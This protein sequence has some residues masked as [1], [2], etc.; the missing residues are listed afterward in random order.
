MKNVM[1]LACASAL[2]IFAAQ[3]ANAQSLRNASGPAERPPLSYTAS[4]FVDSKGCVYIRAG[5][6]GSVTWVPRV[7][8]S[9]KLM[10]GAKPSLVAGSE[11]VD[12]RGESAIKETTVAAASVRAPVRT[13]APVPAM[14][15]SMG[16]TPKPVA[17][18]AAPVVIKK[19]AS[20]API[21]TATAKRPSNG[22]FFGLLFGNN[23]RTTGAKT[24]KAPAPKIVVAA[25]PAATPR[26]A[27]P[28]FLDISAQNAQARGANACGF[29]SPYMKSR[30][31]LPVRCTPQAAHPAALSRVS[32]GVS[33]FYAPNNTA[34]AS[35][36]AYASASPFSRTTTV[37]APIPAGYE[38]VWNDGR[39]NNKRAVG[40]L[41]G[42]AAQAL[43]WTNTVPYRLIDRSTGKDVTLKYS[44]LEYPYTDYADQVAVLR[45][46]APKQ[47]Y[48]ITAAA[49]V[50][51]VP[52]PQPLAR[53]RTER[54]TAKIASTARTASSKRGGY[55]Q[56]GIFT[57]P[58]QAT[59]AIAALR[60]QGLPVKV[61][62]T[63]R[64]GKPVQILITGPYAAN[65]NLTPILA[66]VKRAGFP[67]AVIK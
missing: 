33:T 41:S 30:P 1:V 9:G 61:G 12:P 67:T 50:Q 59:R 35:T 25:A 28:V 24:L 54:A 34:V 37:D 18:A 45:G 22:G 55:V 17:V 27:S 43:V 64:K 16:F 66:Q 2:A 39:L 60:A 26:A 62:K 48:I 58:A 3:S 31:G 19:P 51:T 57:D 5:F 47:K 42:A 29:D 13:P 49:P 53:A 7:N 36:G 32:N 15:P 6:G 10:C 4:Q 46:K 52:K 65:T 56:A 21:K 63:T 11:V 38:P 14:T 20:P 23:N 40:N 8:R 44:Y